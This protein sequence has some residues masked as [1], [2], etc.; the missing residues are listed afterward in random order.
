[1]TADR[2]LCGGFN[3]NI[4]KLAKKHFKKILSE[5]KELKIIT[6]GTKDMIKSKMNIAIILLIKKVLKRK[7]KYHLMRQI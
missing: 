4:C 5:G 7:N 2:G 3:A 1:M 6:V